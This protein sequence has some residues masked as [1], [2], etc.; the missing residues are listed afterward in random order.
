M[1]MVRQI[2]A[3]LGGVRVDANPPAGDGFDPG[4]TKERERRFKRWPDKA[5][6]ELSESV[7]LTIKEARALEDLVEFIVEY[8]EGPIALMAI[9]KFTLSKGKD[10]ARFVALRRQRD[11]TLP[12]GVIKVVRRRA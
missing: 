3:R 10:V 8:E 11:G 7:F 4:L 12:P 6:A 5:T 9:D 1:D 2:A